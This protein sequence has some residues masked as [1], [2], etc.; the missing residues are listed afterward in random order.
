MQI[1]P[2]LLA[3]KRAPPLRAHALSSQAHCNFNSPASRLRRE[4]LKRG[5]RGATTDTVGKAEVERATVGANGGKQSDGGNVVDYYKNR[6]VH[7]APPRLCS[8]SVCVCTRH[9]ASTRPGVVSDRCPVVLGR[10]RAIY[11]RIIRLR[12]AAVIVRNRRRHLRP[13]SGSLLARPSVRSGPGNIRKSRLIISYR[14]QVVHK[15]RR[16]MCHL[17]PIVSIGSNHHRAV[18][19]RCR[20]VSYSANSWQRPELPRPKHSGDI[21]LIKFITSAQTVS[22]TTSPPVTSTFMP[23]LRD[24]DPPP[25]PPLLGSGDCHQMSHLKSGMVEVVAQCAHGAGTVQ[26]FWNVHPAST[27]LNSPDRTTPG[28]AISAPCSPCWHTSNFYFL[29]GCLSQVPES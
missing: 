24:D 7:S 12:L 9:S 16:I 15:R 3:I 23:P 21:Y 13:P 18:R 20:V 11:D 25:P 22:F 17:R 14:C 19:N 1:T 8:I 4:H 27:P 5:A 2:P 26:C 28:V 10:R 29:F 6:T